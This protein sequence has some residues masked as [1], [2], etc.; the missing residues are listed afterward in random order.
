MKF[1]HLADLHIGKRVNEFPMVEDQ[2]YILKQIL[3]II[4]VEK[5]DGG[6]ILAGDLYDKS[7]PSAEAV[8]ILDDF[9]VELAARKLRVFAIAGNHDSPERIAFGNRLMNKSG[10]YLSSVYD[11]TSQ[12]ISL[13]DGTRPPVDV[14]MLPF[15]KPQNVRQA[16]PEEKIET[17]TDA[18]RVAIQH[19]DLQPEHRNL[20]ITH[21]FVSGAGR[22]DSEEISI[23]GTDNVDADVFVPFDYVALG[24]LHG[25][26]NIHIGGKDRTDA[27]DCPVESTE[28]NEKKVNEHTERGPILRYSGTPLKYSFSEVNHRKSVTIV[29]IG[30]KDGHPH[31]LITW[32]TVA[33]KPMHDLREIRGT[34]DEVMNRAFYSTINTEDY[35]HVTLTDEMDVPD[36]LGKLRTVYHRLMKLDYDNA[37]TKSSMEALED[38][39]DVERKSPMELFEELYRK[40]NHQEMNEEQRSFLSEMME[41][42]WEDA[43]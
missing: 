31:A 24:H 21:Q 3:E 2:Q 4:D 15:V 12:M 19:M 43:Q 8:K 6:I 10:I 7:I 9:L 18:V 41:S 34:Y 42:I 36:A 14:W 5:P 37:R 11:G 32:R 23:G 13:D 17:Y 16:F 39:Q 33:L 28:K 20:L 30:E 1:L 29:D 40:Q 35:V 22:C 25:P 26:Q 38:L 27:E